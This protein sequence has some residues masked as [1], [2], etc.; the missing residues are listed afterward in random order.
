M[1]NIKQFLIATGNYF[2]PIYKALPLIG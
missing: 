2:H 1:T